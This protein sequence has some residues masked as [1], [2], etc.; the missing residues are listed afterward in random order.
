MG[1]SQDGL[2]VVEAAYY[3]AE[4]DVIQGK[5]VLPLFLLDVLPDKGDVG[6]GGSAG[7]M[8]KRSVPMAWAWGLALA[9]WRGFVLVRVLG[10]GFGGVE[11]YSNAYMPVPVA[12]SR[13]C[14]GDWTGRG[15]VCR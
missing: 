15:G 11:P 6:R 10:G 8:V 1:F 2:R 4:V 12:T 3:V 14:L 7:C 5:G 13:T 9:F